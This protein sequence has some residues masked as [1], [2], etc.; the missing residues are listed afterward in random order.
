MNIFKY[1]QYRLNESITYIPENEVN[2]GKS[3]SE[4]IQKKGGFIE[5]AYVINGAWFPF[6]IPKKTIIGVPDGIGKKTMDNI[7]QDAN[8]KFEDDLILPIVYVWVYN[9]WMKYQIP[10]TP[11]YSFQAP[12]FDK[13]KAIEISEYLT[14][15]F[16]ETF[17]KMSVIA[18]AGGWV[19]VKEEL[20]LNCDGEAYI[21]SGR[22][23]DKLPLLV[24][25]GWDK[26]K[27]F[28]VE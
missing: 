24:K 21:K 19:Y 15:R 23:I 7:I 22:F 10:M 16:N 11:S 25:Y 13:D 12:L 28:F 26:N 1:N 27:I 8:N 18:I 5:N 20:G 9:T 17:A 6:G 14:D 4:E 3:P 2:G